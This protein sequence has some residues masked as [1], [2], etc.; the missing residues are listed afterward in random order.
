MD[1]RY[2]HENRTAA[3]NDVARVQPAPLLIDESS[4][5]ALALTFGPAASATPGSALSAGGVDALNAPWGLALA[6]SNFGK[7][8]GDLLVGNFGSGEITAFDP[9]TGGRSIVPLAGRADT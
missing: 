4:A 2:H 7:Y 1:Y 3:A 9:A 5:V 6:P 8:S